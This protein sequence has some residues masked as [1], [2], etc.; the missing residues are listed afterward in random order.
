MGSKPTVYLAGKVKGGK[1]NFSTSLMNSKDFNFCASDDSNQ[2]D[3]CRSVEVFGYEKDEVREMCNDQIL[4]SDILIAY[5]DS[6]DAYGT[7]AE[8]A[9]ASANG[10]NCYVFLEYGNTC[11]LYTSPSPRDATLSRMPSSA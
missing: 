1:W 4:S 5:I 8:I 11:L 7:I 6:C 2:E 3:H 10:I 9:Y